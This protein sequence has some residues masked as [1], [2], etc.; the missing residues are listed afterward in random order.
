M[1]WDARTSTFVLVDLPPSGAPARIVRLGLDGRQTL[2]DTADG[3]ALPGGRPL[4][5]VR[6]SGIATL[7]DGGIVLADTGNH[8][9]LLLDPDGGWSVLAGT[10][11]PG[12]REDL[13]AD[14][15]LGRA[16]ASPLNQPMGVAATPDG[17]V[18]ADH[19]NGR[20]CLV[21]PGGFLR[22]LA[23]HGQPC[24]PAGPG[25][26]RQG[27]QEWPVAVAAGPNGTVFYSAEGKPPA[28]RAISPDRKQIRTL[29]GRKGAAKARVPWIQEGLSRPG[30]L[31]LLPDG[32]LAVVDGQNTVLHGFDPD[33]RLEAL[34]GTWACWQKPAGPDEAQ[35]SLVPLALE[36]ACGSFLAL[37]AVP[38]GMAVAEAGGRIRLL[39]PG[40]DA[41]GLTDAVLGAL[42]GLQAGDPRDAEA[43]ARTL[44]KRTGDPSSPSTADAC[45]GDAKHAP[46]P[47]SAPSHQDPARLLLDWAARTCLDRALT[48]AWGPQW[49]LWRGRIE[50]PS[51]PAQPDTRQAW[52]TPCRTGLVTARGLAVDPGQR[53]TPPSLLVNGDDL[54]GGPSVWRLAADGTGRELFPLDRK[55]LGAALRPNPL[56]LINGNLPALLTA[57]GDPN[58]L[59]YGGLVG[60]P[61]GCL[62]LA[63]RSECQIWRC[64]PDG[65]QH[66]LAGAG[67]PWNN[68]GGHQ[69]PDDQPRPALEVILDAPTALATAPGDGLLFVQPRRGNVCR[70]EPDGTLATLAG[71]TQGLRWPLGAA[72][73]ADGAVV[74]LDDV[75]I[76]HRIRPG[77]PA[78]VLARCLNP[79]APP[80]EETRTRPP[81]VPL[82]VTAQGDLWFFHRDE[83]TLWRITPDRRLL[84]GRG[85]AEAPFRSLGGLAPVPGR[86]LL[87]FERDGR[88]HYLCGSDQSQLD[89]QRVFDRHRQA[90]LAQDFAA[91]QAMEAEVRRWANL[92]KS[93]GD[94]RQML[95]APLS[96]QGFHLPR[97]PLPADAA[98]SADPDLPV[99]DLRPGHDP[100]GWNLPEGLERLVAQ[101]VGVGPAEPGLALEA[102]F[103]LARMIRTREALARDPAPASSP[104]ASSADKGDSK[105]NEP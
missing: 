45:P 29:D 47:G 87:A 86:G 38:G 24:D 93:P 13:D 15:R 103:G 3:K 85:G 83:S 56:A 60:L 4:K 33:G 39:T 16:D 74:V 42:A 27:R 31:A 23:R 22:T 78:A 67:A 10:G 32:T 17:V 81:G 25:A 96:S 65:S 49:G 9:V 35:A 11:Q 18:V 20:V 48:A 66:L 55:D 53:G 50:S 92:P 46:A 2:L 80:S 21:T 36:T 101:F 76:I 40:P 44:A 69:D 19:R 104:A 8:R 91:A 14:G 72:Q 61:N 59:G 28:V 34:A 100:D 84:A 105:A 88:I 5:L 37:A 6:Q 41:A 64:A 57:L 70:L 54:A 99:R 97:R 26:D 62:G 73:T 75:G 58:H 102:Q 71:P 95:L 12:W 98:R 89:W 82:A 90:C 51:G 43:L 94:L 68:L 7:P 77:E 63:D 30:A 79:E 1:A 52:L